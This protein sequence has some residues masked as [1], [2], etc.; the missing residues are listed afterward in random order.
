MTYSFSTSQ[1]NANVTT[2]A[3]TTIRNMTVKSFTHVIVMIA[4]IMI[5]AMI[6]NIEYTLLEIDVP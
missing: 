2:V 1:V 5:H 3:K 6:V 4:E